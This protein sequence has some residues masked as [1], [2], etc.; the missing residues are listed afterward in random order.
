MGTNTK[1]SLSFM[2][3]ARRWGSFVFYLSHVFPHN[4]KTFP[5]SSPCIWRRVSRPPSNHNNHQ[6]QTK[7]QEKGV[8]HQ[9]NISPLSHT[10][11]HH[12][13]KVNKMSCLHAPKEKEK[14]TT[15]VDEIKRE[16]TNLIK[17]PYYF[18][19]FC[20]LQYHHSIQSF[21]VTLLNS[22]ENGKERTIR[23]DD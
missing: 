21:I 2:A 22:R 8:T 15:R 20:C 12:T 10:H 18:T 17:C 14:N 16:S 7:Q 9:K 3:S 23:C 4:H 19:R 13:H 1:H 5:S 6:K 11:T